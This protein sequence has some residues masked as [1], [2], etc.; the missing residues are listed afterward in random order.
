M[1]FISS[2]YIIKLVYYVSSDIM[3]AG[4]ILNS[5]YFHQITEIRRILHHLVCGTTFII[6]VC[7]TELSC[8]QY[9]F[10][11]IEDA[12]STSNGYFL[13]EKKQAKIVCHG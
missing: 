5:R 2:D 1:S 7:L 11:L 12:I 3:F 8:L 13:W 4:R 9:I 6:S 10:F